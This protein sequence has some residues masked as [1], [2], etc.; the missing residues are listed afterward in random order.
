M[1]HLKFVDEL[2]KLGV[3]VTSTRSE[4]R[5]KEYPI[6]GL[7]KTNT[8]VENN[9]KLKWKEY[10]S[11]LPINALLKKAVDMGEYKH[12]WHIE[13]RPDNYERIE[14]IIQKRIFERA[15]EIDELINIYFQLHYEMTQ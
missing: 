2:Q 7:F 4:G 11:E 6:Y 13:M 14:E 3:R 12:S 9:F 5:T 10:D 15:S 1:D 8:I